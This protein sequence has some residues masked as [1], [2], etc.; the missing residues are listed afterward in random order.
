[1]ICPMYD[2]GDNARDTTASTRRASPV[3]WLRGVAALVVESSVTVGRRTLRIGP[4]ARGQAR[5]AKATRGCR[6]G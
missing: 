4:G 3:D 1:V 6:G 2:E 5:A